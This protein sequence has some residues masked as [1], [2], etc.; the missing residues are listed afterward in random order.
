MEVVLIDAHG[1]LR[2]GLEVL[3]ERRGV[4]V[5]GSTA[6][7]AGAFEVLGAHH[8]DVAVVGIQLRDGDG[9]SLVRELQVDHSAVPVLVYTGIEDVGTLG[10]A[11]ESGARG[12]LLKLGGVTQLIQVLRLLARGERYVD[13]TIT[14][15]LDAEVDGKPLLLTKREREIF[16]LLAQG[17][18]GKEIADRLGVSA[19]TVRTHIRNAMETLQAHTRTGAVV[20]AL[21]TNEIR[22]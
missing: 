21:Q 11:L 8:P 22:G 3:L 9:L 1:A 7:T 18:S 10:A 19:E 4:V 5:V 14:A 17:L 15:L 2:E 20:Q 6:T 13:P 16:D 12:F